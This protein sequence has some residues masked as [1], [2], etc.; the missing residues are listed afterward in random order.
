MLIFSVN[1]VEFR[2]VG[3]YIEE[4]NKTEELICNNLEWSA[5]TIAEA[6]KKIG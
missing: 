1:Q 5:T 4:G 6:Y 2:R 3:V